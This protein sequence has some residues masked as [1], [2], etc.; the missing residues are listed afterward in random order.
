MSAKRVIFEIKRNL[1]ALHTVDVHNIPEGVP[2]A[3]P[4][5]E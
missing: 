2:L 5:L 1:S 3:P 4:L